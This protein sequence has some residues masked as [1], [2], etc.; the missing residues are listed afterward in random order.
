MRIIAS[1]EYNKLYDLPYEQMIITV[2]GKEI[3]GHVVGMTYG[4]TLAKCTS[5]DEAK[6]MIQKLHQYAMLM[7][8][9]IFNFKEKKNIVFNKNKCDDMTNGQKIR[10]MSDEELAYF[11]AEHLGCE[12]C[13][14]KNT[15][16]CKSA[17]SCHNAVFEWLRQPVED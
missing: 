16:I 1:E 14:I 11:L 13:Q 8:N 7:P 10:N 3:M 4:Y 2:S 6:E 9:G 5:T 17:D 12:L 15:N